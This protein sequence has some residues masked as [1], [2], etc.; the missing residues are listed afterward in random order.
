MELKEVI[1]KVLDAKAR[2]SKLYESKGSIDSD[3]LKVSD[4][5]DKL[6]N[7]HDRL[8]TRELEQKSPPKF[9]QVN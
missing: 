9:C 8:L 6:L 4:E 3:V 5:I 7:E 2:L 1:E